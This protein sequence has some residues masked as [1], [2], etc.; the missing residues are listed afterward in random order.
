[1]CKL[2]FYIAIQLSNK[3]VTN[4]YILQSLL[5]NSGMGTC[6]I[7][8]F[9]KNKYLFYNE[10]M[11]NF[12]L[13]NDI[14]IEFDDIFYKTQK[15]CMAFKRFIHLYK[16]KKS[17]IAVD[18]DLSLNPIKENDKHIICIYDNNTKYLFNILDLI[19]IIYNSLTNSYRFFSEP[20]PIKNP[21][22][23][24]PFN[25]SNLYNIYFF[26]LFN[27][28]YYSDLFY[29]FFKTNFNLNQFYIQNEYV[30]RDY[31]I[32]NYVYRNDAT[33]LY[34]DVLNMLQLYNNEKSKSKYKFKININF[35]KKLLVDIMRPY[36]LLYISSNYSLY[37]L[38]K[39]YYYVQLIH[40]LSQ[41]IIFNPL[42][43]RQI[44][45][46]NVEYVNMKKKYKRVTTFNEKHILYDSCTLES[47][48]NNHSEIDYLYGIHSINNIH[49][50]IVNHL[51]EYDTDDSVD[52][53]DDIIENENNNYD[54]EY[55]DDTTEGDED[56]EEKEEEGEEKEGEEKEEE[57]EDQEE[58]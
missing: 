34:K 12:F 56:Q 1:M 9:I 3:Y 49:N 10:N 46:I 51:Y 42:F 45:H 8:C 13:Q 41:F 24:I 58:E 28:Y 7:E 52:E 4:N 40:K 33:I 25:K 14:K 20:L 22:N 5:F 15:I 50:N 6:N 36:L 37:K 55:D 2:F 53:D 30:L 29:K 18:T 19:K 39:T 27:T 43:G 16:Y 38:H 11:N 47:F 21:Y 44:I 35:P 32:Y 48:L 26:I 57:G 31:T 54:E 17:K 23:N